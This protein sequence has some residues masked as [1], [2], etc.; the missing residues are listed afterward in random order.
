MSVTV[1]Y[2]AATELRET[3]EDTIEYWCRECQKN[4]ELVAGETAWKMLECLAVAKQEQMS[5]FV[6]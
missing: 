5:R 3:I 2:Q 6:D 1:S 4:G